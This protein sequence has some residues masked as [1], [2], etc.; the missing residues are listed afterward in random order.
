VQPIDEI[1]FV[2]SK[3][4]QVDTAQP[5]S[6]FI[7]RAEAGDIWGGEERQLRQLVN[8]E[9]VSR[10]VVFDTWTLNCDRHG[11][12]EG[13]PQEKPR[14]NRRNVFLSAEAPGGQ[15]CLKAIDHTHC[16]TCGKSLTPTRLHDIGRIKDERVFGLFPEF[17]SFLDREA[18]RAV[19]KRLASIDKS[20]VASMMQVIPRDWDVRKEVQEAWKGLIVS[21]ARFVADTIETKL[22]PQKE[23]D[24]R[25]D[26]S[27]AK[28]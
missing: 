4:E 28:P 20:V 2:N 8:L 11:P 18:V 16:F 3:G 15:L 19:A 7:T 1:P 25:D 23:L 22:W 9:D 21:R 17:R 26:D 12:R 13:H 6:A 5:G 10:L 14:I 24:L 27:E